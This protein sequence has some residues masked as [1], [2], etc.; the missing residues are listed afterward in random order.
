MTERIRVT[1]TIVVE[2]PKAWVEQ[3]LANSALQLE[4][5]K[6]LIGPQGGFLQ[7]LDRIRVNHVDLEMPDVR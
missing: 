3:T 7:E 5:G 2:G 6:V 4:K 1:R